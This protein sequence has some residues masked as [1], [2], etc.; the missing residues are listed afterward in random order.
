M[1]PRDEKII[2]EAII[3][4]F[5]FGMKNATNI[6]KSTLSHY[7]RRFISNCKLFLEKHDDRQENKRGRELIELP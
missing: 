6:S 4:R 1:G 5:R 3:K 7:D 2:K